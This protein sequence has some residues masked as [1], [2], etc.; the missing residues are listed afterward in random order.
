VVE[1]A[2]KELGR[3]D[4][5]SLHFSQVYPFHS[6]AAGLLRKAEKLV[7]IEGNK[8]GQLAKLIKLYLGI[9]IESRIFK[10]NGLQYTVEE[11]VK[12][13]TDILA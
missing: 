1:E 3:K 8:T 6:D 5:A 10:Y 9:D 11:L 7:I 4:V 12:E 2:V 13:L